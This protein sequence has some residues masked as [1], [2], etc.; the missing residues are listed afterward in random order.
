MVCPGVLWVSALTGEGIDNLLEAISE[1][2]GEDFIEPELELDP[3][4]GRLRAKFYQQGVV[5][6][7]SLD[8]KGAFHLSLRLQKQDF[9]RL[10]K[11][12]GLDAKAY[13]P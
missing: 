5:K 10:L 13:L 11:E 1:L 3:K 9:I 2:L 8:D 6:N 12:E 7:E 4:Y